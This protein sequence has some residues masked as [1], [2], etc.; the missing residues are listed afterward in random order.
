MVKFDIIYADPPWTF[1]PWTEDGGTGRLP[2]DKYPCLSLQELANMGN[3]VKQI[4][5]PNSVLLMW[6]VWRDLPGCLKVMDAWGFKYKT[7]AFVWVKTAKKDGKYM[8]GTGYYTRSNTEFV[9]LG[10]RGSVLP[11]SSKGVHE[12]IAAPRGEHSRKP[13][14][15]YDRMNELYSPFTYRDRIELFASEWSA[16]LAVPAYFIPIGI[17]VT[18][19]D[20]R[21]DLEDIANDNQGAW[22]DAKNRAH[23]YRALYA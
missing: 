18:G 17:E 19:N 5:K 14:Q 3:L 4:A 22:E 15:I 23:N 21:Q 9:L 8:W 6:G 11:R 13:W 12:I 7:N 20:I 2:D 1:K 10:T 16:G